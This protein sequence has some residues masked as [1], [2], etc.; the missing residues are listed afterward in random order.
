MDKITV[1]VRGRSPG[2]ENLGFKAA[3]ARGAAPAGGFSEVKHRPSQDEV[4]D[5]ISWLQSHQ[6]SL[7]FIN[8]QRE[9]QSHIPG[10]APPDQKLL[11]GAAG[12]WRGTLLNK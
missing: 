11:L 2:S 8:K 4:H 1:R 6:I 10:S 5:I 3:A 12:C 9:N 7:W